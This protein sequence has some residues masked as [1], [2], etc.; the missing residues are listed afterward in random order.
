MPRPSPKPSPK[1][2]APSADMAITL[3]LGALAHMVRSDALASRFLADSGMAPGDVAASAADPD[4]LAAVL[5]FFLSDDGSLLDLADALGFAPADVAAA[6]QHLP[7]G[8]VPH[9]T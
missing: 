4:F 5:D 1:P 9:W 3:A 2:S 6:R 7:G 8:A